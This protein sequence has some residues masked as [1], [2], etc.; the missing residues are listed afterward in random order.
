MACL[1]ALAIIAAGCSHP[2]PAPDLPA[3]TTR[4]PA[5]TAD[6]QLAAGDFTGAAAAYDQLAKESNDAS[7]AEWRLR[8]ALIRADLGTPSGLPPAASSP[9]TR[10]LSAL[11]ASAPQETVALLD[12]QPLQS[13]APFEVGLFL[14]TLGAAQA[15][16]GQPMPACINLTLAE[17]Y[18]MPPHRRAEL[19]ARLW[20]TLQRADRAAL[21]KKL[22]PKAP[23]AAGWLALLDLKPWA[24]VDA[25]TLA[26]ALAAWREQFPNHPAQASLLD[27][28]I[29]A[30]GHRA[31]QP[32]RIALLLPTQ[33][34]LMEIATA[35]RDG[36]LAARYADGG[37]AK[38]EVMLFDADAGSLDELIGSIRKAQADLIIGPLAKEQV[39]AL[40]ARTDLP[41][42]VL[43]LNTT[44]KPVAD[45]Q[46]FVQFALSPEDEAAD[47]ANRAWQ[48]GVRRV[49]VLAANT[50]L[51]SRQLKAF[52]ARW[53]AL[54]GTLVVATRFNRAQLAYAEA[55]GRV[56]GLEECKARASELRR[57]LRRDVAFEPGPRD[58]IDAVFIAG[59][60][61]DAHQL[62]PQFR[63]VGAAQVPVYGASTMLE[64][65]GNAR[66]DQD[67]EGLQ[68]GGTAWATAGN[69]ARALREVLA[70]HWKEAATLQRFHAFG[71]D[72]W[73]L[74]G[75]LAKLREAGAAPVA[76][77][78]GQ[79]TLDTNGVVHRALYW[80]R[81]RNGVAQALEPAE[82]A[83]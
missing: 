73:A 8:A 57:A 4:S 9:R 43:A 54:G 45:S 5:E 17:R 48:D 15:A 25:A 19:T 71:A 7:S 74:A 13:L 77:I 36:L 14:R 32:R 53:E 33:G 70:A 44:S 50:S 3:A 64:G 31:Q 56:F 78:T 27:T 83:R 60:T 75:Q 28:L 51:G 26:T 72:A 24:A 55:A 58:D 6:D 21:A 76:G 22:H 12:Q 63:Y 39:D 62:L 29:A 68:V 52:S 66:A 49:A 18:P 35:V 47:T 1:A 20:D 40:A 16:L 61:Q 65:M 79:L 80:A 69:S 38:P 59:S 11:A 37:D 82:L 46:H 10:L 81:V 42:P 34:P 67:V 2:Q 30:A 23:F 41:A